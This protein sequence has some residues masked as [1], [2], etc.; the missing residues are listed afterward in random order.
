[1]VSKF[2]QDHWNSKRHTPTGTS[3]SLVSI[4]SLASIS[5]AV[6][7]KYDILFWS[8]FFCPSLLIS[9]EN[10][11]YKHFKQNLY[12]IV[13]SSLSNFKI[14]IHMEYFFGSFLHFLEDILLQNKKK[15]YEVKLPC[16]KIDVHYLKNNY[17][18]N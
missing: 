7:H 9:Y 5:L 8:P 6:L 18:L 15:T 2:M 11:H 16:T 14:A 13:L 12:S 17:K 4:H 1:M 10:I 3:I